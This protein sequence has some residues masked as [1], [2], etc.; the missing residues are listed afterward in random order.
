M[1]DSALFFFLGMFLTSFALVL[2]RLR[3]G[4][5][6]LSRR[7]IVPEGALVTLSWSLAALVVMAAII[8]F[9]TLD[10]FRYYGWTLLRSMV[11]G[12]W[13]SFLAGCVSGF[14]LYTALSAI[15][16]WNAFDNVMLVIVLA[17]GPAL[18]ILLLYYLSVPGATQKLGLTGIKA[19]E[20]EITLGP[21][22]A[23]PPSIPSY[24][25]VGENLGL[26]G[27]FTPWFQNFWPM[28]LK[29][30]DPNI[31][32]EFMDLAYFQREARYLV[33]GLTAEETK[34]LEVPDTPE[35]KGENQLKGPAKTIWDQE[36]FIRSLRPVVGCGAF[37]HLSFPDVPGI[38]PF[39]TPI[40]ETLVGVE[41]EIEAISATPD[42]HIEW[43]QDLEA[44]LVAQIRRL[45]PG[46]P[47]SRLLRFA[48]NDSVSV[49][50][51]EEYSDEAISVKVRTGWNHLCGLHH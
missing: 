44:H 16:N 20:V 24:T 40:L 30:E 12:C 46:R 38:R 34:R 37:Y 50:H 23:S 41:A 51:C 2:S 42:N 8:A 13:I 26:K 17:A 15:S 22:P 45:L 49:C 48:R 11:L 18:T 27:D 31:K 4:R 32:K 21:P 35:A 14:I 33:H 43:V 25:P 28:F 29:L 19:G 1:A 5:D 36:E 10:Y 9:P 47:A 3:V 7:W 39:L 6:E